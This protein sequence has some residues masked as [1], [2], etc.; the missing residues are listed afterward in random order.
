MPLRNPT[1]RHSPKEPKM[2]KDGIGEGSSLGTTRHLEYAPRVDP[3]IKKT[4]KKYF[5]HP[6]TFGD[7]EESTRSK[8]ALPQWGDLF[9]III[10]EDYLEYIPH[11]NLDLRVLNDQVFLNIR[12]S[13]L[14][15]VARRTLVLPYI[16]VLKWLINHMDEKISFINDENGVCVRFFL[17]IEVHKYYKLRDLEEWLNIDFVVK[18][19]DF[20]DTS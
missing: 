20:H 10:E 18:F 17:P 6:P 4:T 16:E 8:V 1:I 12:R 9:N 11:S 7:T 2:K 19:Y 13:Y 14:H 5:V 15:M 3:T